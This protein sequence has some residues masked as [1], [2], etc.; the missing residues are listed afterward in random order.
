[1]SFKAESENSTHEKDEHSITEW[2]PSVPEGGTYVPLEDAEADERAITDEVR[3][4]EQTFDN[5]EAESVTT[6]QEK[7]RMMS[8]EEF[9]EQLARSYSIPFGD[10]Q[11]EYAKIEPLE[12][13]LKSPNW[14]IFVGGFNSQ[15]EGYY[16]ELLNLAQSGRKILFVNPETN[17]EIDE[18]EIPEVIGDIPQVIRTEAQALGHILVHEGIS[19][20]DFVAHS[21]G[22]AVTSTLLAAN[23]SLGSRV[24]LDSP[25]GLTGKESTLQLLK[26]SVTEF[27]SERT[28]KTNHSISNTQPNERPL[29]HFKKRLLDHIGWK[30]L[31]EI[32]AIAHTDIRPLLEHIRNAQEEEGVRAA[33]IILLHGNNDHIFTPEKVEDALGEDPFRYVDRWANY[34]EK[35]AR[36]GK[37]ARPHPGVIPQVFSDETTGQQRPS[38]IAH[39][40]NEGL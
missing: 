4:I 9:D 22:C 25:A 38:A 20:A 8:K 13:T 14:V 36:H 2:K 10:G 5:I 33:E 17:V 1:M 39:L 16:D 27:G 34:I 29:P 31:K 28:A 40:L 24:L 11:I 15:K 35:D 18:E 19:R 21:R 23:P 6:D 12:S 3:A 26:R 7:E 37:I 30:L 32:P